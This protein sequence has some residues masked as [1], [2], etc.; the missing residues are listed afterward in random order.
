MSYEQYNYA[1]YPN[2]IVN[3]L[4]ETTRKNEVERVNSVKD[5]DDSMVVTFVLE[6]PVPR[7]CSV[8]YCRRN[9]RSS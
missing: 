9:G 5:G 1:T 3:T 6:M 7:K 8:I 4:L 2:N